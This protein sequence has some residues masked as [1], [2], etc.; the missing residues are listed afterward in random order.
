MKESG[1]AFFNIL[2]TL[3]GI[4]LGIAMTIVYFHSQTLQ[5]EACVQKYSLTSPA[6]D[7]ATY[8]D[9]SARLKA[10]DQALDD[11]TAL[12]IKEDKATRI[13]VWVRDLETKQWAAS[14]ETARYAPASL[15]K[16]P[17]MIAYYKL[18]DIEPT[19]LDTKLTYTPSPDLNDSS[20]DFAPQKPLIAGQSYTVEELIE[21]MIINSDNG[22]TS[23][24]LSHIDPTVFENTMIDL[25]IKVPGTMQ[26]YDFITA[27]TY[28]TIFR[29]LY[30]ASYLTR[31]YSEKALELMAKSTFAG[32]AEPLPKDVIV[33]HKF[34]EREVLNMDGTVQKRELHDCGIVY[35]IPRSYSICIMTEG[36]NF[37]DL[38]SVIQDIS[39]IA[40]KQL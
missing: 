34:G 4:L 29:T 32:M 6:L 19:I 25:G 2:I 40:Y 26:N 30:N 28:A 23:L 5:K 20:Q 16:L 10:L 35:K 38:L 1:H 7:C 37:K 3:S 9:S 39:T 12:Y 21:N 14:N 31:E 22:A 8:E 24:L 15:L 17:L 33:S 11:A 13:S 18:S 36:S 27:K